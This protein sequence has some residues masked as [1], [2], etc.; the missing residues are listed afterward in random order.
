MMNRRWFISLLGL[1]AAS[2]ALP[3]AGRVYPG[4]GGGPAPATAPGNSILSGGGG[5]ELFCYDGTWTRPLGQRALVVCEARG[6]GGGRY[7]GGGGSIVTRTIE[8]THLEGGEIVIA[9]DKPS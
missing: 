2:A 6:G 5:S 4:A 9:S 1:G 8:I 7:E 3:V